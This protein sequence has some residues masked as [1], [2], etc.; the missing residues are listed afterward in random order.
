MLPKRRQAAVIVAHPDDETLWCSGFIMDHPSWAWHVVC[1]SRADDPDR[2]P[3][4]RRVVEHLGATGSI[5]ALDDSPAQP[6]LA[7]DRVR[8]TVLSLLPRGRFDLVFTHGPLGEYTRHRRH[9]ECCRA[10]VALWQA[11]LL[12]TD[13]LCLFAY[14]DGGGAYAPQVRADA[15]RRYRLSP[16]TMRRKRDIITRF[17]GFSDQSWEARITPEVEGFQCFRSP[18]EAARRVAAFEVTT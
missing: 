17:Y 15:D 8:D 16:G 7:G 13:H 11:S 1:L 4:F 2:A 14:E 5:G 12:H 10:V 18:V 3:K 9:E 6:S